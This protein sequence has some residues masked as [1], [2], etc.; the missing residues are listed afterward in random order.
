MLSR[1]LL[2]QVILDSHLHIASDVQGEAEGAGFSHPGEEK[3]QMSSGERMEKAETDVCQ[4]NTATGQ[5]IM[6]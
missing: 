6:G 3:G 5:E 1:F 4:G 2:K